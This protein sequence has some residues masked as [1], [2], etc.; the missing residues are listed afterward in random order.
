MLFEQCGFEGS[1]TDYNASHNSLLSHALAH[2]RGL[3]IT[4]SVLTLCIANQLNVPL[5]GVKAPGHFILRKPD[6]DPQFFIDPFHKGQIIRHDE[7][8]LQLEKQHGTMDSEILAECYPNRINQ[9]HL[10]SHQQQSTDFIPE[11]TKSIRCDA[12]P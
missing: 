5:E 2:K 10:Y 11:N 8:K 4:L 7:L 6:A 1:V 3:P 9:R 12:L